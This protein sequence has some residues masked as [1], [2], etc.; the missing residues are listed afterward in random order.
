MDPW[1]NAVMDHT[2]RN[3]MYWSD[4]LAVSG[5]SKASG[6]ERKYRYLTGLWEE[7]LARGMM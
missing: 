6:Q 4:K 3:L 2:R 5:V 1:Y 7:N